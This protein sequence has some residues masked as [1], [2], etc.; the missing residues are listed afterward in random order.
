MLQTY[1]TLVGQKSPS[2]I[3]KLN[4]KARSHLRNPGNA[5]QSTYPNVSLLWSYQRQT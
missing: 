1:T 5:E 2:V 3:Q 4:I